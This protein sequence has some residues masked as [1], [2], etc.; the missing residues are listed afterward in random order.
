MVDTFEKYEVCIGGWHRRR[1]GM[2]S[3][4]R[5]SNSKITFRIIFAESA[6]E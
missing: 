1:V 5:M 4:N 3:I 6:G 2:R